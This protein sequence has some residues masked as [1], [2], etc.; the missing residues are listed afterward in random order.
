MKDG[1]SSL[2]C[3]QHSNLDDVS[4][5]VMQR[6]MQIALLRSG[7]LILDSSVSE[8]REKKKMLGFMKECQVMS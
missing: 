6:C 2:S 7:V 1:F 3:L 8:D 4:I 5:S